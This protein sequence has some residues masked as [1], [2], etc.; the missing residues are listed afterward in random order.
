MKVTVQDRQSAP[1]AGQ[2]IA[3]FL[4]DIQIRRR[5]LEILADTIRQ[6]HQREPGCWAVTLCPGGE[7]AVRLTV[8]MIYVCNLYPNG[9]ALTVDGSLQD[10]AVLRPYLRER[11]YQALVHAASGSP[12]PI[13]DAPR[14]ASLPEAAWCWFHAKD[15]H[16]AFPLVAKAYRTLIDT[17][18]STPLNPA[19]R[20]ANSPGVVAYLSTTLKHLVP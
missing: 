10:P 17:A 9:I 3:A 6:A 8:G 1:K 16:H 14:F 7:D 19:V 5:C 13:D 20:R 18:T 2:V 15:I 4:P 12:I 11:N